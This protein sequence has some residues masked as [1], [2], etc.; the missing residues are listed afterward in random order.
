MRI[1][2][3]TANRLGDAVL[4]TGLLDHLLRAYPGAQ[5]TIACGPVAAGVF[6]RMP[7]RAA[8]LVIE[9]RRLD[10]H[11]L[12]LWRRT[13]LTVWD[14]VVDLRGSALAF[15]VPARRRVVLR[16]G[17]RPG[18]KTEQLAAAL[19]VTP[20][21]LPT[22]WVAPD[23]EAY[24]RAALREGPYLGLGP[25]ANWAGKVWPAER[26]VALVRAMP[27]LRPVVFA[28]PGEAERA[29]AAPV[30]AALPGAIDLGGR[31]TLPQASACLRRCA[32]FV[33]NDSGLMHL[34]AAAG[35]PTLGLFGPTPAREYGPSG[36]RAAAVCADGV[37]GAGN[38]GQLSVEQVAEAAF[39][40]SWDQER[41]G[42]GFVLPPGA[43]M[44][45]GY[46]PPAPPSEGARTWLD[47]NNAHAEALSLLD[48]ARFEHLL[49]QAF[50]AACVPPADALMLAFDQAAEYDSANF[51]WFRQRLPRFAY[52]DRVVVAEHARGRGLARSLYAAL[53]VKAL[54]AG[55]TTLACEVNLDPPN[56]ASDAFHAALGFTEAGRATHGGRTVRYLTRPIP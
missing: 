7:R 34:S 2:F 29:M 21:P 4:S 5:F 43:H 14:L 39:S 56:P 25:T 38:M 15:L 8:T 35:V 36:S 52:I 53:T 22:C 23:D 1:L 11:W 33:G 13:A 10:R 24:A 30:L 47:L 49:R 17:R 31:L 18:H 32:L 37:E 51:L 12:G 45:H 6:E 54:A 16:G 27:G 44:A 50:Y 28:G 42:N 55:H 9:K 48:A 41:V 3:I 19:G 40:L 20:P 26:F 46:P